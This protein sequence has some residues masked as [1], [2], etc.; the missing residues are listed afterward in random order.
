MNP[1]LKDFLARDK[2]ITEAATKGLWK[3]MRT[4]EKIDR[5]CVYSNDEKI[6]IAQIDYEFCDSQFIAHSKNTAE[7]KNEMIRE[8][9]EVL[10]FPN[11]VLPGP[12]NKN[13][14]LELDKALKFFEAW[15]AK[16]IQAIERVEAL[17]RTAMKEET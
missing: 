11:D 5:I 6:R 14:H 16:S 8:M 7:V 15:I 17:A 4:P 12:M 1:T 10:Q 2:R 13:T 3:L 9:W